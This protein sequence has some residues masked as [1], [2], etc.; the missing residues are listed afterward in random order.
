M[1]IVKNIECKG[2]ELYFGEKPEK[3]IIEV[4]KGA[5]FRWHSMKKCWY[6]KE[7]EN[8]LGLANKILAYL[9]GENEKLENTY[10][11]GENKTVENELGVKV[12]DIFEMSWGYEQ[13]N[14]DFFQ[15][16]ALKGKT[17]V[18]I[19]E[20]VLRE[21]NEEYMPHGMAR[22]VSFDVKHATPVTKSYFVKDNEKGMV[23]K[24]CGTKERPY[25]N[26]ASYANAYKY[27]GEKLYESWY[28]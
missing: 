25:L 18:I 22:D 19:K 12:G 11:V 9:S 23:K 8:T 3:K 2:I 24:V 4:L 6:A 10:I 21:A 27:N 15:V 28:Y 1:E 5:K 17:Q 14:I 13:T 20:V 26:M 7:N 16:V